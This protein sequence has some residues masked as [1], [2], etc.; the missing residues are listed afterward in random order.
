M[1]SKEGYLGNSNLKRTKVNIEYTKEQIL[2]FQK[3]AEDPIYFIRKYIKIVNVD[4]G[5]IPFNLWDFQAEMIETAVA[6]RFVICKMPR[7]VGKTTTVLL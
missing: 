5:L 1:A 4:L 7:Q 3:C 2:E 6:E